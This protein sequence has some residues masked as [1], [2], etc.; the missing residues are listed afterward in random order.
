MTPRQHEL[1]EFI[2]SY[3]SEKGYPP[4]M[5]EMSTGLGLKGKATIH[6]MLESLEEQ[7]YLRRR[8]RRA[9]S[10]EV[11]ARKSVEV[12]A[13]KVPLTAYTD[14]ELANEL[15]RRRMAKSLTIGRD[16]YGG[17]MTFTA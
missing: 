7:G 1:L 3:T 14:D 6:R 13:R 5:Q 10:V 16:P 8:P 4:S 9:R 17:T 12:V 2:L 15:M 11:V